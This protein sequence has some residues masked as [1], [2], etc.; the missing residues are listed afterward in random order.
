MKKNILAIVATAL[1]AAA[2]GA[3]VADVDT[4][5]TDGGSN[6][7]SAGKHWDAA[8]EA[9]VVDSNTHT[10]SSGKHWDSA[11]EACVSDTN[12]PT[13]SAGK[14][15]D[16]SSESCVSDVATNGNV[17]VHLTGLQSVEQF[18][19]EVVSDPSALGRT[20]SGGGSYTR[21]GSEITITI[22]FAGSTPYLRFSCWTGTA[23]CASNYGSPQLN[24]SGNATWNGTT[25][26]FQ[27]I[28]VRPNNAE[29]LVRFGDANVPNP[30]QT[31]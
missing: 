24:V 17:V 12:T 1:I 16:A 8:A 27:A 22:P 28:S 14:H 25:R 26:N 31:N 4:S 19:W 3:D 21:S 6:V 10:C 15:W 18:K 5:G 13:C 7:C 29:V 20:M 2:C 9:C 30:L 11:K 23:W